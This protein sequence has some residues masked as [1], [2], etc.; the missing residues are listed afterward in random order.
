M[1][2]CAS[3]KKGVACLK[4]ALARDS[5]INVT[6]LFIKKNQIAAISE[7]IKPQLPAAKHNTINQESILIFCHM[8]S[9]REGGKRLVCVQKATAVKVIWN[10]CLIQL[11][12][13]QKVVKW[14]VFNFS[15]SCY[16]AALL[17]E[18]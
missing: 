4:A 2:K 17:N 16:P 14:F 5:F 10:W 7:G 11:G 18:P 9:N 3:Q 15:Q 6:T 8:W 13:C 12:S 1:R